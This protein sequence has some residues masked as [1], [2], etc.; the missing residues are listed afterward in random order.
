MGRTAAP[1]AATPNV[2]SVCNPR[3]D[4]GSGSETA[5]PSTW[6][7]R[8]RYGGRGGSLAP[9]PGTERESDDVAKTFGAG[10]VTTLRGDAATERAVR[11]AMAGRDIVH[12]ATHGL[13]SLRRSDLLA[14]L[15]L[16][17]VSAADLEDDG[18]LQMFEIFDLPLSARLV[19][20]SACESSHGR[21]AEGEGVMALSNG[22]HA[23]GARQ[24]VAT[25]WK[26]DDDASAVLMRAFFARVA[27]AWDDGGDVARAL[28]D[29]K[30][31]VRADAGRSHPFY[32]AAFVAS[33]RP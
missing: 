12:L 6:V 32:W 4:A 2:L 24:V 20:L 3:F 7:A 27:A 8:T 1:G 5:G 33:G 31:T 18:F 10:A 30:R 29:A 19:V 16:T 15:A 9:L 13:V 25:L 17:P 26:V 28:R 11:D 23:A 22:F 21:Y 14:A